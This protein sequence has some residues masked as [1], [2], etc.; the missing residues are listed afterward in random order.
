MIIREIKKHPLDFICLAILLF[1]GLIAF[2]YFNHLPEVQK[3][4]VIFTGIG[5]FLW[6][7]FH[8]WQEG[9]L[10]LKIVVEY[11]LL[12]LLGVLATFF[13]ILRE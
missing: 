10:S 12:A 6:G 13:L 9:D 11:F 5:Y 3:I 4:I 1:S 2:F 8:H 7:I